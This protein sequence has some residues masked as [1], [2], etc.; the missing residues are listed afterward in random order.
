[1]LKTRLWLVLGFLVVSSLLGIVSFFAWMANQPEPPPEIP[2]SATATDFASAAAYDWLAGAGTGL[3]AAEGVDVTFDGTG[4]GFAGIEGVSWGGFTPVSE[5]GRRFELHRFI[6]AGDPP[7]LLT[8]TVELTGSGPVLASEPSLEPFT[9]VGAPTGPADR[10]DRDDA[11]FAGDAATRSV[12]EWATA[13]AADD[14]DRLRELT[15]DL[16]NRVY[17]GIGGLTAAD[18]EV[19]SVVDGPDGTD[20]FRVT[21]TYAR[22]EE[23]SSVV[24]YDLLVADSDTA[25]P[26]VVA[27]GPAGSGTS[28]EPFINGLAAGSGSS[29]T[30]T[31]TTAPSGG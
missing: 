20:L 17:V 14:R 9:G 13:Y 25:N 24:S 1:V 7:Q 27:W 31:T 5:D 26:K 3:P 11:R 4:E 29:T 22:G 19:R 23:W 12:S 2:P 15:G 8:V 28:L 10:S 30:T 21:V 18:A 6:L 16:E